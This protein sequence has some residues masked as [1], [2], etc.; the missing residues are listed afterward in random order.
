MSAQDEQRIRLIRDGLL[1]YSGAAV[2]AALGLVLVPLMIDHLGSADYGVWVA[3]FA[4][5]AL[6]TVVNSGLGW[7]VTRQAAER[8]AGVPA[9]LGGFSTL[10]LGLG[11]VGCLVIAV[12]GIWVSA[13]LHLPRGQVGPARELFAL[14]GVAFL[15]D[16][17]TAYL[18]AALAGLR[19]FGTLNLLTIFSAA[20]RVGGIGLLLVNGS[21]LVSI[22][23]WQVAS[24]SISAVA[25]VVLL[26]R[27][28]P[29]YALRMP[30][31]V[32]LAA[33][34][35]HIRFGAGSLL[36]IALSGITAQSVLILIGVIKGSN[37]LTAFN[38]GQRFPLVAAGL[39]WQAAA[40]IFPA[41]SEANL[42][43]ASLQRL[44]ELL[45]AGMRSVLLVATPLA[46]IGIALS[47]PLLHAWLG[48]VPGHSVSVMRVTGLMVLTEAPGNIALLVLWAAGDIRSVVLVS[49]L[50]AIALVALG[51]P[52]IMAAG[53]TAAAWLILG[54]NALATLELIRRVCRLVELPY[55]ALIGE[56]RGLV[57][58]TLLCGTIAFGVDL[59]GVR[60][61]WPE[62]VAAA[63]L[64]IL[65][66]LVALIV[67]GATLPER[68]FA[69]S[70]LAPRWARSAVTFVRLLR[71]AVR[72]SSREAE[73]ELG[74]E[75]RRHDPWGYDSADG[76]RRF[77]RELRLIDSA[78]EGGKVGNGLEIGCAEGAFTR[79]LA[80]RCESL[81]AVDVNESAIE[82][83]RERCRGI[84]NVEFQ[85]WDLRTDIPPG[86]FDLVVVTGVLEYFKS[87]R[88]LLAAR[89]KLVATVRP[90]G[91]ILIG[92]VRM[93]D[94]VERAA[95]ASRLVRGGR[96][97]N[98]F[99]AQHPDLKVVAEDGDLQYLEM[100][101]KRRDG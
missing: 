19:R 18:G 34:R 79:H 38:V 75:F 62:V 13:G 93:G 82:R 71:E 70:L 94:V 80:A 91:W 3:A 12:V 23:A 69:R 40:V 97:V 74:R 98:A 64:A 56:A 59:L 41:A 42:A 11:A 44:R 27:V 65:V 88:S 48:E 1:N 10:Y 7:S 86:S 96:H 63:F 76:Q 20:V 67:H 89:S 61:R 68:R 78:V 81:L 77:D 8:H 35:P 101:L 72:D 99:I 25:G 49:G 2:T 22:A 46:V 73:L 66:Y 30:R 85:R 92:N 5:V 6:V 47:H 15:A 39:V 28:E 24:S 58:P 83:A 14:V 45:P 29:R 17:L 87:R 60:Q 54:L 37:A 4:V 55:R 21:G 84:P 43:G 32:Y 90:G 57:I 33:L 31:L 51:I 52:L 16:Q 50:L 9:V 36:I 95:W 26:A 53:I 100:L